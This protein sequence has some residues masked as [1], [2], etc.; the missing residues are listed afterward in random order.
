MFPILHL[1]PLAIQT[2]GLFLLVAVWIGLLITERH[3]DLY[4]IP[5]NKLYTLGLVALIS[6]VVGARLVYI[7]Q[8]PSAFQASPLGLISPNPLLLDV[9]G[10][11]TLAIL[12]SLFYLQRSH[13]SFWGVMDAFTS[14]FAVLIIALGLAHLADGSAFGLPS[15]VPW[16]LPLWGEHRQP[17]QV[18]EILAGLVVLGLTWPRGQAG[19]IFWKRISP[20]AGL[21]FAVFLALSA[22]TRL[23]LEAFRGDSPLVFGRFRL[24]MLVAWGILAVSLTLI[25]ARRLDR[26]KDIP[27]R[28]GIV[29]ENSIVK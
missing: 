28:D 13:L 29:G 20:P 2:P 27:R 25:G 21:R 22:G 10:G 16:S 9:W 18:Y 24:P 8:H 17:S 1:G 11:F 3:A 15:H 23:F 19:F 14:C 5:G 12:A 6:G 4:N 7:L 26:Q